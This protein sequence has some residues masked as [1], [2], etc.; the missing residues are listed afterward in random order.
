MS[1]GTKI[2]VACV[3]LVLVLMIGLLWY[4]GTSPNP[5][6]SDLTSSNSSVASKQAIDRDLL[7][8]DAQLTGLD[9][10]V[11]TMDSYQF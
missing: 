7:A 5:G 9:Q 4:A 3:V 8:A 1:N 10:D 6:V 2:V 11:S